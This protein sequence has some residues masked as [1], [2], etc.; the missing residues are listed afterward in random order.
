MDATIAETTVSYILSGSQHEGWYYVGGQWYS[1]SDFGFDFDEYWSEYHGD[2]E[3]Y[4]GYL[5]DWTSGEW[6]D[7]FAGVTY[8]IYDIQVNPTISDS[9]FQPS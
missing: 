9:V 4:T 1:F 7:T 6:S 3:T 5:A 8:R 2:F